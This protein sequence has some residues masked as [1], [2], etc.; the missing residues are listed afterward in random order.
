MI[1]DCFLNVPEDK[2][3][4]S[5]VCDPCFAKCRVIIGRLLHRIYHE[6]QEH[7]NTSVFWISNHMEPASNYNGEICKT[8]FFL[9]LF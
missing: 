7:P 8:M 9:V 1:K 3:D 5:E 2:F 4:P 6:I